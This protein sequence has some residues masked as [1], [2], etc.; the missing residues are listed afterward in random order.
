VNGI[1]PYPGMGRAEKWFQMRDIPYEM[2]P[3]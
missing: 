3:H 1:F 2:I